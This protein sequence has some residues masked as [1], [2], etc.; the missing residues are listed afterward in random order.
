MVS[1]TGSRCPIPVENHVVAVMLSADQRVESARARLALARQHTRGTVL[2][3]R[4]EV[5][6]TMDW[7]TWYQS[8][9][10]LFLAAAFLAGFLLAKRR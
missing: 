1:P 4:H 7:R 5:A 8:R 9:P 3:L 10:G 2:A 6:E